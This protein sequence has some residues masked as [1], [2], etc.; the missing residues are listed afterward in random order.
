M[1]RGFFKNSYLVFKS[2]VLRLQ[3]TGTRLDQTALGPQFPGLQ[4]T[5]T[6]V[7]SLVLHNCE[8]QGTNQK[9]VVTG[10]CEY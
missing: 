4:K 10:L 9:P 6:T 5:E 1:G 7:Q 2:P 3:K 8:N